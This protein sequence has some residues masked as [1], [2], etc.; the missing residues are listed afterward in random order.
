M[1]CILLTRNHYIDILIYYFYTWNPLISK[2]R[3]RFKQPTIVIYYVNSILY[4][5]EVHSYIFVVIILRHHRHAHIVR[6]VQSVLHVGPPSCR[7]WRV[8]GNYCIGERR[9][10]VMI[11]FVCVCVCMCARALSEDNLHS[12]SVGDSICVVGEKR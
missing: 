7:L 12:D 9:F 10:C 11:A 3:N 8:N 1:L 6:I 2:Q 4:R 5:P